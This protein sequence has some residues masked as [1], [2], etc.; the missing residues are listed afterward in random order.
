[1]KK[2]QKNYFYEF[3]EIDRKPQD[4]SCCDEII[5]TDKE[6]KKVVFEWMDNA[7]ID[8]PEDLTWSRMI[9]DVFMDGFK[10]GYEKGKKLS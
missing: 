1:M 6:T 7:H 4:Y 2:E 10:L 9:Y 8:Y 5:I 3:F